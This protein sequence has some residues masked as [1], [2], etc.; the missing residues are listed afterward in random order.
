MP[1]FQFTFGSPIGGLATKPSPYHLEKNQTPDSTNYDLDE[2]GVLSSRRSLI[3]VQT[4]SYGTTPVRQPLVYKDNQIVFL[5]S[6]WNAE[7]VAYICTCPDT[8]WGATP[9][10]QDAL[11][12]GSFKPG[13]S[14]IDTKALI[15]KDYILASDGSNTAKIKFD[16]TR[17]N[18]WTYDP[19]FTIYSTGI[20]KA[21]GG[22]GKLTGTYKWSF[23]FVDEAKKI[24]GKA[25][26]ITDATTIT[27]RAQ[28]LTVTVPADWSTSTT[29]MIDRIIC[30]RTKNGGTDANYY[31][32]TSMG[33]DGVWTFVDNTPDS[34]V[35]N[36]VMPDYNQ[37]HNPYAPCMYKQAG[38]FVPYSPITAEDATTSGLLNGD[39]QW[40]FL[41]ENSEGELGDYGQESSV[42]SLSSS[43]AMIT[44]T[45][46]SDRTCWD[47]SKTWLCRTAAGLPGVYYKVA[48]QDGCDATMVFLDNTPDSDLTELAPT[49]TG[50]IG[51]FTAA[52]THNN[53]VFYASKFADIDKVFF[54]EIDSV[55]SVPSENF[56]ITGEGTTSPVICMAQVGSSVVVFKGDGFGNG[57]AYSIYTPS[58]DPRTWTVSKLDL[59]QMPICSS[60][61][62]MEHGFVFLGRDNIW[63]V[64][65]E[66]QGLIRA[67]PIATTIADKIRAVNQ[68]VKEFHAAIYRN[69]LWVAL[70]DSYQLISPTSEAAWATQTYCYNWA[71]TGNPVQGVWSKISNYAH[72]R[73]MI[74]MRDKLYQITD[75]GEI[76]KYD[77]DNDYLASEAGY[78]EQTRYQLDSTGNPI[79]NPDY[80]D[81]DP[82]NEYLTYT[83]WYLYP[84]QVGGVYTTPYTDLNEQHLD[85]R[86]ILRSVDVEIEQL[87]TDHT[88]NYYLL[89]RNSDGTSSVLSQKTVVGPGQYRLRYYP[90]DSSGTQLTGKYF[91]LQLSDA[92]EIVADQWSYRYKIHN[93]SL[94][95]N[96]RGMQVI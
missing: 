77:F 45:F 95:Y 66:G 23:Q 67:Y 53:R 17:G 84:I 71:K 18:V 9:T 91:Q 19:D 8:T 11:V 32:D 76:Y 73:H 65:D 90:V 83:G 82:N 68:D 10:Y 70:L 47:I 87:S 57:A 62:Y 22:P 13:V 60:E 64:I 85:N 80:P 41:T 3:E 88:G 48:S 1:Q 6:Y 51:K 69:E 78:I 7:S 81:V 38:F 21:D 12:W 40:T 43:Q 79:P 26:S 16:G 27:D 35:L 52:V 20:S 28:I 44:G 34:D 94:Q 92:T 25:Y 37:Y 55:D 58:N 4:S 31:V 5:R 29:N 33:S 46:G 72:F 39:Y 54:T 89:A 50:S 56:I 63:F 49:D 96:L 36:P 61:T 42:L 24:V 2:Y 15:A 30:T 74:A 86:K 14:N 75:P 93:I 59:K